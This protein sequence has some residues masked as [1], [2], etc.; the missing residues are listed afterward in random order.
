[1]LNRSSSF[2]FSR[3]GPCGLERNG[4][5]VL[6]TQPQ[7]HIFHQHFCSATTCT[8][9]RCH[10]CIHR[11][12]PQCCLNAESTKENHCFHIIFGTAIKH[13]ISLTCFNEQSVRGMRAMSSRSNKGKR[14][15]PTPPLVQNSQTIGGPLAVF[16]WPAGCTSQHVQPR[17]RPMLIQFT[18]RIKNPDIRWAQSCFVPGPHGLCLCLP[19]YQRQPSWTSNVLNKY[20]RTAAFMFSGLSAATWALQSCLGWVAGAALCP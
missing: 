18:C 3:R 11:A 7:T 15:A 20:N 4:R 2:K 14:R 12:P 8:P 13:M 17:K 5:V 19:N 16:L 9:V 1:M 10:R 6:Q